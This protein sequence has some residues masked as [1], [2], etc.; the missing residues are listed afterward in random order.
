[1]LPKTVM[2]IDDDKE[3]LEELKENLSSSD[4][5]IIAV[6][7]PALALSTA[8]SKKPDV[9]LVDLR[10]PGK[11]GFLIADEFKNSRKLENVPIIAMSGCFKHKDSEL[12]NIYGFMD[13]LGKPF[14]PADVIAKIEYALKNTV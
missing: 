13:Y 11:S 8:L 14:N 12:L 2:I 5:E 9:I 3:F 10:M 4:Y 7:D 6:K 1:M